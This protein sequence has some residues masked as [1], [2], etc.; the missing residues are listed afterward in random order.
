MFALADDFYWLSHHDGT[1]KPRLHAR[2]IELGCA[3]ALLAELISSRHIGVED[4]RITV[5]D[6]RPPADALMHLILDQV[7]AEAAR[8]HSIRTWL[9]FLGQHAPGQIAM[10]LL[11]AGHVHMEAQR[12]L[13]RQVGVLYVPVDVN[14]AAWPWAML[15]QHLRRHEPLEYEPLCLAGLALASGLH[16]YLLDGA[17]AET[18]DYLNRSVRTLWTP[19]RA[20][21][22][23]THA[24][25][26]DAVLAHR[27]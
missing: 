15:S 25:I 4:D 6:S 1:G 9:A 5:L 20:L 19:M 18:F 8:A 26:G 13:G 24:A 7:I 3:A 17:P 12:K 22:F 2:A 27:T 21:L 16:T 11:R 10:R 23:H 14:V